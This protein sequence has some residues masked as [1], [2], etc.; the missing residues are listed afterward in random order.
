MDKPLIQRVLIA[1]RGEIASRLIRQFRAV[2]TE[3]AVV[4]S[5]PDVDAP[6]V[7][8]ADYPVY[9]NGK[10]VAETYLD[11]MRV[12]AAACDAGCEAIH[13]GYCFLAERVDF[14]QLAEGANVAVIGCDLRPLA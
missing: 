2:G 13:P 11:P 10:T 12:V 5:E 14:V 3:T 9:L 1:N 8:E 7:E 4:F 6:W